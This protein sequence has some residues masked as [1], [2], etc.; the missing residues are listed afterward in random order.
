[1]NNKLWFKVLDNKEYQIARSA[2]G[3]FL[4]AHSDECDMDEEIDVIAEGVLEIAG[5]DRV[6]EV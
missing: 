6:Q 1:M 3:A 5:A 4:K 2:W